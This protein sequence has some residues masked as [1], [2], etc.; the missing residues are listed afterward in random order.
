MEI[1]LW[2]RDRT[3]TNQEAEQL[4]VDEIESMNRDKKVFN[5]VMRPTMVSEGAHGKPKSMEIVYLRW[6]EGVDDQGRQM[7]FEVP[8]S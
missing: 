3:G 1:V 5:V 8:C 2:Q 6:D 4:W 7:V